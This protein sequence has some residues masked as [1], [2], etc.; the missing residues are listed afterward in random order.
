MYKELT[1]MNSLG[2]GYSEETRQNELSLVQDFFFLFLLL[3]YVLSQIS[4]FMHFSL[5][6]RRV[7]TTNSFTFFSTSEPHIMGLSTKVDTALS[8]FPTDPELTYFAT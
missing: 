8:K 5:L 1:L 4:S 2:K 3:L 6:R 7:L